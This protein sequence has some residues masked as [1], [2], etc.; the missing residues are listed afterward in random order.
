MKLY[1][2]IGFPMFMK[3]PFLWFFTK[4]F[5]YLT[6]KRVLKKEKPDLIVVYCPIYGSMVK[7]RYELYNNGKS[8]IW[9][10]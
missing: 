6:F 1:K 5:A 10:V 2:P 8:S 3:K 7:N 4:P 9:F